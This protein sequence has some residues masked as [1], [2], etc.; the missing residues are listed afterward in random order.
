MDDEDDYEAKL[1]RRFRF[2]R[3]FH[4]GELLLW[5][6]A[7][8]VCA[9]LG[10]SQK[11]LGRDV[12]R[13][14]EHPHFDDWRPGPR[15]PK[16]GS[17][18]T[19]DQVYQWLE[20]R[21]YASASKKLNVSKLAQEAEL[22]LPR[23]GV[24]AVDVPSQSKLRRLVNQ[25]I[26]ME[27]AF[28]AEMRY[29]RE[30]KRSYEMHDG[31]YEVERPLQVVCIDHTR[32]DHR[33]WLLSG[34]TFN[35]LRPWL[36]AAIDLYTSCVLAA[37]ISPFAPSATTVSLAMAMMATSKTPL[38]ERYGIPGEWEACG[39]P[40]VLYVDGAAELKSKAV[41]RGCDLTGVT[42]RVGL[43]GRP[44][45]RGRMERF[46]RTL[47]SEIHSWD[48]TTLSNTQELERHGGQTPPAWDFEVV[49]QKLLT[50]VCIYNN[51]TYGSGRIPPI[52]AWRDAARTARLQR[53]TP[54]DPFRTFLD[55]LPYSEAQIGDQ[56]IEQWLCRYASHELR[57]LRFAGVGRKDKVLFVY[58]PRDVSRIWVHYDGRYIEAERVFPRRAPKDLFALKAWNKDKRRQADEKRDVELLGKL[59]TLQNGRRMRAPLMPLEG[60]NAD[61]TLD[62]EPG[63]ELPRGYDED[64]RNSVRRALVAVGKL[65]PSALVPESQQALPLND[66]PIAIPPAASPGK[67]PP[68]F[69]IPDFASRLK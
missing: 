44:E 2:A 27:P 45:R 15:G 48:G 38:L 35:A 9:E 65:P 14:A 20:Q 34:S 32:I 6:S 41:R 18:R 8:Q 62:I 50:A 22:L 47:N 57:A 16:A 10:I 5:Y 37:F 30:G 64:G 67:L 59:V 58:D 23:E 54:S 36:T 19:T 55:F 42:L 25:I 53:M 69:D 17:H 31:T 60:F 1:H 13:F 11:T 49:Q 12:A 7:T 61:G 39:L 26:A 56:G 51:E 63:P 68:D 4:T 52:M 21:V 33:T 28:F 46:W 43:P 40:E 66:E 3:A 29:G 24:P